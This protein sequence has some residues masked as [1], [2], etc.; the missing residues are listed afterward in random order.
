M[1]NWFRI[2]VGSQKFGRGG[3]DFDGVGCSGLFLEGILVMF[4]EL[5]DCRVWEGEQ[6]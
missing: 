4:R 6:E 2:K 1:R 3:R 5:K